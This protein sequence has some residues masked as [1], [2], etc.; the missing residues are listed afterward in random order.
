MR[1]L[2]LRETPF[3]QDGDFHIKRVEEQYN[4][5]LANDLGNLIQRTITMVRKYQK[6]V[7]GEMP[8][9]SHDVKPYRQAMANFRFDRAL[10]EIWLLVRGLNQYIEEEKPWKIAKDDQDHL[11][12]E[13]A[14][15][16][17][18]LL[19]VGNLLVPFMP[20]TAEKIQ[21]IFGEGVVKE[22]SVILFPRHQDQ[23]K[24]ESS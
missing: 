4:A 10:E 1:Y 12:E 9:H 23:S 18:N 22:D 14:Y 11:R 19:Q 20:A 7:I 15:L 17:A 3:G 6:G 13:L 21:Q 24:V 8:K 2:L 16:A 5:D